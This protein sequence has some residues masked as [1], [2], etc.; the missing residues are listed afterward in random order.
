M[1]SLIRLQR[2]NPKP[3]VTLVK[4]MSETIIP[5]REPHRRPEGCIAI[6]GEEVIKG[7]ANEIGFVSAEVD[8]GRSAFVVEPGEIKF[9]GDARRVGDFSRQASICPG[10]RI[11]AFNTG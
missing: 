6:C 10:R 8:G 11:P 3:R 1:R 7:V 2:D 5:P 4:F 9:V